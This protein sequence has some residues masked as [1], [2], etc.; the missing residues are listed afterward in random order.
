VTVAESLLEIDSLTVVAQGRDRQ[1]PVVRDVS[2]SV[3]QGETV[4]VVG[5]TGSGKSM[6]MLAV[7]GLLPSPPMRVAAGEVRL[8][9]TNLLTLGEREYRSVR[10]S[11]MAMVYQDPLTSL[12]PLMSVGD[13]ISEALR[14]HGVVRRQARAR[15]LELLEL[16]GI[17][18]PARSARAYPHE[19][20]GGMRQRVM[21]GIALALSPRLLIADE[22]TT[23]L[24]A[25]IQQQI[26]ALVR[27]MQRR[28]GMTVIWITH[29]LGVVARLAERVV[30]MY[31]GEVVEHGSATRIFQAPEHPYT[32]GLLASLPRARGEERA[33]L[34]QIPGVPPEPGSLPK[35][36]AFATRCAFA[37]D[38]CREE[39]PTLQPRAN[40]AAAC[41]FRR[42]Q[43]AA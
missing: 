19:F 36:C 35:G 31:A 5:E 15:T 41:W 4:C 24:D 8:R 1:T 18:D 27:D 40:G 11:E 16:V 29:D 22:P 33:P 14:A 23:A 34:A 26:M 9:G 32:H 37:Q 38:R 3:E 43:W 10:G 21:I 6:T 7:M 12:N 28:T 13:Q 2:I 30:V 39:A 42:D 20:S 17:P 25:T